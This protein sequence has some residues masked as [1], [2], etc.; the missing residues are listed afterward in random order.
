MF[1]GK[2]LAQFAASH[3][4]RGNLCQRY[5]GR[6]RDVGHGARGP[7]IH[8]D[9]VNPVALN[10][11]LDVHQADDFERAGQLEGVFANGVKQVLGDIDRRQH[12]GRVA[13]VDAGLFDV[14]HDAAD[15]HV[16]AVGD[17]VY[18]NLGRRLEEVIDQHRPLLRILDCLLHVL[19]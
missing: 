12:A 11:V 2:K 16:L 3:Q 17:G 15:D 6:L 14:L 1:S 19:R 5:A 13:G 7:R 8:L 10:G 4:A 9:D 18:I